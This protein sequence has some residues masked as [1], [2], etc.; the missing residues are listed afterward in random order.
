[1]QAR[2]GAK[3]VIAVLAG[4]IAVL[5]LLNW[6]L[7]QSPIDISPIAPSTGNVDAPRPDNSDLATALDKKSAT[8]FQET[9][10]RPLFNPS[11]RPA[12]R[13]RA[14]AKDGL[15]ETSDMRLIGVM[16]SGDHPPRALIR[17][18]NAQTGKWL[19][20]G[21]Q[22]NG[23]KLRKVNARSIVVEGSGRSHELTLSS[24]RRAPDDL[25]GPESSGKPR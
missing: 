11:R 14:P 23:W 2:E 9:A 8:Q 3:L 18:A 21:E 13:D 17:F 12:Q 4:A 7:V 20:E 19:A 15:A 10:S 6:Y 1:M 24:A 25:P 22:F 5:V 16:K